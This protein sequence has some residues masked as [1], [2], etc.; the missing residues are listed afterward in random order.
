[1]LVVWGG[2]YGIIL[3]VRISYL[4]LGIEYIEV[5]SWW[6]DVYVSRGGNFCIICKEE[7][8]LVRISVRI[9]YL[10]LG[11]EY[12]GGGC[13]WCDIY[14][15]RGGGIDLLVGGVWSLK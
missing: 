14:V 9:S 3:L 10:R 5:G 11:F 7:L 6:C 1:M 15:S 12:I 8:G 2:N 13:W 4:R